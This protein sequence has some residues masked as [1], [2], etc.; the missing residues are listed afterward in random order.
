MDKWSQVSV[1]SKMQLS[2]TSLFAANWSFIS[3]IL[4]MRAFERK[5]LARGSLCGP[6]I[7]VK[8][9]QLCILTFVF[10]HVAASYTCPLGWMS[11]E[12]WLVDYVT[13]LCVCI[14]S[15]ITYCLHHKNTDNERSSEP[16]H[17][18]VL[19]WK[20]IKKEYRNKN[21]FPLSTKSVNEFFKNGTMNN[22]H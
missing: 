21:I 14:K 17:L 16:L 18:S 20:R 19:P 15:S 1:I 13:M 22:I 12:A 5:M 8:R 6:L 3:S 11:W 10:S 2:F 4:F 9:R 7:T